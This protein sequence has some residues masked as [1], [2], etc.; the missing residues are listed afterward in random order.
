MSSQTVN[1]FDKYTRSVDDDL[2]SIEFSHSFSPKTIKRVRPGHLSSVSQQLKYAESKM[3][4]VQ[5]QYALT[6]I[7]RRTEKL[8]EEVWAWTIFSQTVLPMLS[9]L[10]D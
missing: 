6:P 2:N 5:Q 4:Q 9:F 8:E 10:D 3:Q 1:G 7:K